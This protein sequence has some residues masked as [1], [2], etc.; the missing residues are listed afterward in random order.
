MKRSIKIVSVLLLWALV[1]PSAPQGMK[2]R[3]SAKHIFM[4]PAGMMG[5]HVA[6]K[7][8]KMF[9]YQYSLMSMA[10]NRLGTRRID[11]AS[12]LEKFKVS[13]TSM[14][15]Q[16][17]MFGSM[18][19]LQNHLTLM[20]MLPFRQL[21][22]DHITRS[23]NPFTVRT[24]GLGDITIT[25]LYRL[26]T[27]PDQ[28]LVGQLGLRLPTG[29]INKRGDL[30]SGPN[31]KLAYPMQIGSGTFALVPGMTYH[32]H[33]GTYSYG[34]QWNSVFPLGRNRF[35]YRLGDQLSVT[36]WGAKQLKK[37]LFS[38]LRA[39]GNFWSNIHGQDRDLDPTVVPTNDPSLRGGSR[40]DFLLGLSY[41]TA[42][43][44]LGFEIGLPVYQSLDGPQLE[45]DFLL[46]TRFHQIF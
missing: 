28:H 19:R 17:H 43:S 26:N 6:M 20:V 41:H 45:T 23:S 22:M 36:A 31:A 16:M 44:R 32:K 27:S 10:G 13:P 5:A 33:G 7:G 3:H 11:E 18:L 35:G 25:G 39:R 40:V 9:S 8:M 34:F 12:V 38:S 4:L 29:S 2:M 1:S 42:K 14:S 37:R 24:A 15:M 46:M 30:P 21:A